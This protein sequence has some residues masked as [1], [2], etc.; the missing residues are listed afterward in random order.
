[1]KKMTALLVLILVLFASASFAEDLSGLNDQELMILHQEVLAELE[2]RGIQYGDEGPGSDLN[3]MEGDEIVLH[4]MTEFFSYWNEFNM[5]NMLTL[6]LPEW[7]EEVGNPR[8]ALFQLLLNRTP[9]DLIPESV[10]GDPDDPVRTIQ[11]S[12]VM[13]RN[14]GQDPVRYRLRIQ[15]KKSDDGLWYIDPQSLKDAEI[16]TDSPAIIPTPEPESSTG[17]VSG[18]T[19]LYFVPEG[20]QYYHLDP[21]CKTVNPKFL[22]M[23]GSFTYAE[24]NN[25]PYRDRNPCPVCEA[26]SR[27]E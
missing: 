2:R 14:N 11:A 15:M 18:S 10:S 17:S 4:R 6:C 9:L 24:V 23:G 22:P 21:N 19:L 13:D 25:E 12:S 5:D 16:L 8:P 7:K 3:I 20:G 26:P 1:M 27:E